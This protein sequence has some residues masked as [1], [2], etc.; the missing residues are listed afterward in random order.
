MSSA[1]AW[2]NVPVRRLPISLGGGQHFVFANAATSDGRYLIGAS[3]QDT[4]PPDAVHGVPGQAVLYEVA[5][6]KVVPM[7]RLAFPSSQVLS[8]AGDGRWIVWQEAND[9]PDFY[10]WRLRAYDRD[11][12][13][14]REIARATTDA[15]GAPLPGPLSFVAT[16]HGLAMWGQGV[17]PRVSAGSM[18][19]AVVR[20]ADLA[21][22]SVT[23]VAV[24]AG[25]PALSWPWAAWVVFEGTGGYVHTTNLDTG[26]TSRLEIRPASLSLSGPNLAYND[27]ASLSVWL[28][29]RVD[30]GGPG[31]MVAR[32]PE[33]NYLEWPTIN[34]RI[35]AWA[36]NGSST[37]FDRARVQ[38]VVLP[39]SSGWSSS[40]ASGPLLVWEETDPSTPV[41]QGWPD[42][43]AVVDTSVLPARP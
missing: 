39:V 33:G 21:S 25:W 16:G 22:G 17:G 26:R 34:P 32:S 40:T 4:A 15:G 27:A 42:R 13:S 19:D 20:R 1:V 31:T 12:G 37:V 38:E 14:V 41:S 43:V 10:N 30:V 36:E 2:G 24:S 5:S 3:R 8:A 7:A 23:T 9:E 18:Q 11:T 29:D 35:V 28:V 6:G